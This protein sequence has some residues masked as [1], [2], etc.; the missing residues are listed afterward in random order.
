[1]T[2]ARNTRTNVVFRFSNTDAIHYYPENLHFITALS[3]NITVSRQLLPA[4]Y[5]H[6]YAQNTQRIL[7]SYP[8]L[9]CS[10][11]D[12]EDAGWFKSPYECM[13]RDS[14]IDRNAIADRFQYGVESISVL[15]QH[16]L[17]FELIAYVWV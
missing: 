9:R 11:L 2:L 6:S 3:V 13:F 15:P 1:M 8:Y 5:I 7:A 12:A 4:S 10:V 14:K 16:V 17:A